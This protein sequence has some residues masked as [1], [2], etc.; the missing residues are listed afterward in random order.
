M[1]LQSVGVPDAKC[2]RLSWV[3]DE[4]RLVKPES[5]AGG[6]CCR[7]NPTVDWHSE[8]GFEH[9]IQNRFLFD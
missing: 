6:K 9:L 1:Y 8:I 7:R 5:A 2:T 4:V 3:Q